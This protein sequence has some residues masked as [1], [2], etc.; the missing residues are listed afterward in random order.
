MTNILIEVRGGIIQQITSDS[1]DIDISVK[2]FDING[3]SN[4]K[5]EWRSY[6]ADLILTK[7]KFKEFKKSN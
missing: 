2:D 3:D 4:E 7:K 6:I 5:P 1:K